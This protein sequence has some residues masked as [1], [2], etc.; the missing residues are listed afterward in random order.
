MVRLNLNIV[1][2]MEELEKTTDLINAILATIICMCS[3]VYGLVNFGE[4]YSE[5]YFGLAFVCGVLARNYIQSRE[6]EKK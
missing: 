3:F 1:T 4:Q 6:K 2:D 5:L